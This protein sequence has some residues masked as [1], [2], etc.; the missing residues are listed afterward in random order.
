MIKFDQLLQQVVEKET[1]LRISVG[2]GDRSLEVVFPN[3]RRQR[4]TVERQG[5]R[6]ILTSVV[7][8]SRQVEELGRTEILL[9]LWQRNRETNVVTFSVDKRGKLVGRVEQLADTI[10]S[11]EL[12]LYLELLAR[13]CDQFEYSLT[14]QDRQ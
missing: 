9:R 10:D 14:G 8:K 6:Y 1:G 2:E 11:G 5:E 3:G 7:L 4:I 13:E 12:T